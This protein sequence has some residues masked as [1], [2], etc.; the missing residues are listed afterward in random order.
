MLHLN[1]KQ[2]KST[3]E[4]LK[5]L[6]Q[7]GRWTDVIS[8]HSFNEMAKQALNSLICY[9]LACFVEQSGQ[10]IDWT[11]FPQ[12][13]LYR[14]FEKTYVVFG[15]P[16]QKY[17]EI[18]QMG[19][20]QMGKNISPS[21]FERATKHKITEVV[22][23]Q[24]SDFLTSSLGTNEARIFKAAT[25]IAT[26]IELLQLQ[27][28]CES[29]KYT[30]RLAEVISDMT[31]YN[32][33]PGFNRINNTNSNLFKLLQFISDSY[34]RH[35]TRWCEFGYVKSCTILGHLY[36]TAVWAYIMSLEEN[37]EDEALATKRYFMGIFHDIAEAWT[38]DFPS[39]IKDY[40][41]GLRK[42]CELFEEKSLE[43][44]IYKIIPE[45][46]CKKIHEVM[47]EEPE[48]A[49]KHK[50]LIKGADYFSADTECWLQYQLG[51]RDPY[52]W[53]AI[54]RRQAGINDGSVALTPLC[55]Q[56]RQYFKD[57]CRDYCHL[58]K[59]IEFD[60]LSDAD[61]YNLTL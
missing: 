24:F 12:Y 61:F 20:F 30:E 35:H 31:Q 10:F 45:F 1:Y 41:V 60:Y 29:N 22:D 3:N 13:A 56:L 8:D 34:L 57:F 7:L 33:I 43:E 50:A 17:L 5:R 49:P 19:I 51:T 53:G 32:D 36:S 2:V 44:N 11:R 14:A 37:P 54:L 38:T 47:F 55:A 26:Y 6:I 9:I 58:E 21:E 59:P 28:R 39:P 25:T 46:L 27:N 48:N 16:K 18:F 23:S 15:T 40:I 42:A 52:F 4:M